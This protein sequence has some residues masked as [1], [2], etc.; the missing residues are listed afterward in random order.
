MR[1]SDGAEEYFDAGLRASFLRRLS[2]ETGG[3]YYTPATASALPRDVVYTRSG[4][5]VVERKELWD[6]PVVLLVLVAL[7][8]AEWGYRRARGLV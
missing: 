6:M 4:N 2:G 1:S 5:T 3:R 8:G 7:L